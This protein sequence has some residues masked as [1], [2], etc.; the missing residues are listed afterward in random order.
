M[1]L[2]PK[3]ISA[4]KDSLKLMFENK[5]LLLLAFLP[6]VITIAVTT[7]AMMSIWNVWIA[8]LS[9]WFVVKFFVAALIS[10]IVWLAVGNLALVPFEDAIIDRVQQH[11]W[12]E[13]R[14]PAPD[15]HIMR[16][17]KEVGYSLLVS[18]FFLMLVVL[19]AIPGIAIVSY[20]IAAW[21][22]SWNFLATF[23]ARTSF[24]KSAKDKLNMFFKDPI[25]NA[26]LGAFINF[27]L[28][29]PILNVWLLGYAL[30]LATLVHI[31]RTEESPSPQP[32]Q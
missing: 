24:G 2:D 28:F 11:V 27:L 3:V 9:W 10:L 7:L 14:I 12:G 5:T 18:V 23:Y 8:D 6:G 1:P 16:V 26:V 15:F 22:T 17:V 4:P 25:Q 31:R 30:I 20:L 32:G 29:V 19:S 21:V 13:V